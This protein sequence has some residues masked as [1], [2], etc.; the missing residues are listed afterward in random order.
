MFYFSPVFYVKKGQVIKSDCESVIGRPSALLSEFPKRMSA[1]R[2]FALKNVNL[3][4][5]EVEEEIIDWP[6]GLRSSEMQTEPTN[7][8][9]FKPKYNF[10]PLNRV[11]ELQEGTYIGNKSSW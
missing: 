1:K 2:C 6:V 9:C 5:S 4:N 3:E 7:C 10:T 8:K 11:Y